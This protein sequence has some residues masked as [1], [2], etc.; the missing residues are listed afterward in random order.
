MTQQL[1]KSAALGKDPASVTSTHMA[2]YSHL[3]L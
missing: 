3:G 1:Q 2:T